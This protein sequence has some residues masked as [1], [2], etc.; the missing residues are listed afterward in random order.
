MPYT[1]ESL[2]IQKLVIT[3]HF[4]AY[5]NRSD[6]GL[7]SQDAPWLRAGVQTLALGRELSEEALRD[8]NDHQIMNLPEFTHEP[9]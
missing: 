4:S 2:N 6:L 8:I 5:W 3:K 9:K 7:T 1:F